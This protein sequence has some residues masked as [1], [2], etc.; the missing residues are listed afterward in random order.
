L[1]YFD[2]ENYRSESIERRLNIR[3]EKSVK[4]SKAASVRWDKV[5]NQQV[6][7]DAMQVQ[8]ECNAIKEKDS[9]EKNIKKSNR[10]TDGFDDF[11]DKYHDLTGKPKT[12][13]SSAEKKWVKLTANEK[14]LA[15]DRIGEYSLTNVSEYLKKARTYLEDKSFNDEMRPYIAPVSNFDR[16]NKPIKPKRLEI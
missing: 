11:W 16:N 2:G 7:A 6:D 9:K 3:S 8:S 10:S 12:D 1:F 13:R 14:Q 15:I 4:T 5:K